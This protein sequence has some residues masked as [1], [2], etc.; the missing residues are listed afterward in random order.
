MKYTCLLAA[1]A[2][3]P[4]WAQTVRPTNGALAPSSVAAAPA[5]ATATAPA[6]GTGT[7]GKAPGRETLKRLE[8]D[9]D[10][11][12]KAADKESP[13]DVLGYA[14]G[15]YLQGYG[16]VFT[17]EVELTQNTVLP[18]FHTGAVTNEERARVHNR[19][20]QH[21]DLLRKQMREMLTTAAKTLD[22]A[23]GEQVVVAVRLAYQGW[24]DRSGLPDQIVMR[25]DRRGAQ[26][27]DIK[28]DVQ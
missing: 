6:P 28:M 13:L 25:A 19:K 14:R 21:I 2:L 22:L 12:L 15:L 5:P 1:V 23:Q 11:S 16:A 8:S 10:F 17:T 20:L 24:E 4:A 9:F 3:L 7:I 26:A 27:G 18:M